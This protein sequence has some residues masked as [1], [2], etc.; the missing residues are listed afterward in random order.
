MGPH[1]EALFL[2]FK[3]NLQDSSKC[4]IINRQ[5]TYLLESY[6]KIIIHISWFVL[7]FIRLSS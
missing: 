4:A 1:N 3:K 6:K 7:P 5:K 2:P